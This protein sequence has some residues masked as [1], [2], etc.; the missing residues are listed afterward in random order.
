[1]KVGT[2]GM[3]L[4]AWADVHPSQ[5]TAVDIGTGSGLV[6]LMLAQRHDS[7]RL[8]AVELDPGAAGQAS[9]NFAKSPWSERLNVHNSSIQEYVAATKERVD[10]VVSAPPYFVDDLKTP[11]HE[12]NLA[13]HTPSLPHE[14]LMECAHQLM[15]DTGI[16]CFILPV[17]VGEAIARHALDRGLYLQRKTHVKTVPDKAPRRLLLQWGRVRTRFV[18]DTLVLEEGHPRRFTADYIAL[19]RDF[20]DYM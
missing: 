1:M 3:L 17:D 11:N 8:N 13:R 2:D 4:G 15:N 12:R 20:H 18:E 6:A 9:E 7:L 5:K 16:F 14:T 19:T 10:L